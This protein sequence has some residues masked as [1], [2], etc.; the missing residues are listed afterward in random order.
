[1]YY[2]VNLLNS[3]AFLC[4]L[5]FLHP[6]KPINAKASSPPNIGSTNARTRVVAILFPGTYEQDLSTGVNYGAK[7]NFAYGLR[8]LP[9]LL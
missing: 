6:K 3:G 5:F 7:R 2:H 9:L 1:M 4:D 8:H